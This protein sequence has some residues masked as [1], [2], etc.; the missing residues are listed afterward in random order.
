MLYQLSY[1]PNSSGSCIVK[2]RNYPTIKLLRFAMQSMFSAVR[3]K[4]A[5][6]KT[7]WVITTIFLSR[8]IST[9]TIIALKRYDWSNVFFLR[10]HSYLPTF[11]YSRILVTTPAPTV[12]PPSRMA[13]LEPCSR[14]TGTINSTVRFTL[15]PGITI[16]TPSGRVMFPV[17]SI[18]RM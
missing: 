16:S 14:A 10:S 17:T 13:N 7:V 15:S 12:R 11:S 2:I 6:L 8:V 4:L 3:A 1:W 18:V 9:F 5:E